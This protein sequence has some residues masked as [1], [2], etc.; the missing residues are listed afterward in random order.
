MPINLENLVKFRPCLY[1]LT[2]RQ[3]L[4]A[5]RLYRQLRCTNQLLDDANL[6]RLAWQR[7]REHLVIDGAHDPVLIRDQQPLSV[8]SIDFEDGWTV[9]RFVR[10]IN[11]HVFLWPGTPAGPIAAGRNHFER[12][13]HESP[14][15]IRI[16]TDSVATD[17]LLFS[18]YNSGAPRC[19]GGNYSPRGPSTYLLADKFT[20]TVS[21][22]VEIVAPGKMLLP[23]STEFSDSPGGPWQS[24]FSAN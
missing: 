12:Y 23:D 11:A 14:V 13:R 6:E 3:N 2:S 8:G 19:S 7:R 24:L 1:H 22:V 9:E 16:D 17:A 21:K 20:G 5:I 18:R 4:A 15:I 10:H